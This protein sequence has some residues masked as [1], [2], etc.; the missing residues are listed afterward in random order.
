MNKERHVGVGLFALSLVLKNFSFVPDLL[1]GFLTGLAL[2][3]ILIHIVSPFTGKL[4][5]WKSSLLE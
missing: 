2:I 5:N 1:I 4:K 3:F